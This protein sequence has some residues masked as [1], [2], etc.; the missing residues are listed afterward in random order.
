MNGG[1]CVIRKKRAFV[2]VGRTK[3]RGRTRA[4][5]K[6]SE[7]AASRPFGEDEEER[8]SDAKQ[9]EAS[10]SGWELFV[11]EGEEEDDDMMMVTVMIMM[12]WGGGEEEVGMRV[13]GLETV[14]SVDE[15][16]GA[17]TTLVVHLSLCWSFVSN[18]S[19]V[20]RCAGDVAVDA[21]DP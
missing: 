13:C 18:V 4:P 7:I 9:R 12:K 2:E 1:A 14:R 11:R 5:T 10:L 6:K 21:Q 17:A 16:R 15:R 20:C 8:R 19:D 3:R